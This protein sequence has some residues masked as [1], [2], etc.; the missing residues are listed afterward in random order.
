M[1]KSHKKEVEFIKI[2]DNKILN[3]N[4]IK[5]AKKIDE[6]L[7]ICTK[8]DGCYIGDTHKLCKKTNPESY[9][10]LNKHFQ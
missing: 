8:G 1:I 3:F 2:D 10:K 7:E 4:C 9:E 5:W 6:C